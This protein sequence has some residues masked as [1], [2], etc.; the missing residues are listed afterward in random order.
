MTSKSLLGIN[1]LSPVLFYQNPIDIYQTQEGS[2]QVYGGGPCEINCSRMCNQNLASND[3]ASQ[4]QRQKLIQN[5][6]RVYSSLYTMNLAGLTSYQRPLKTPQIVEQNSTPYVVPANVYWNQM[7]DRARPSHQKTKVASG[8]TYHT[9]STRHSITRN[10]PGAM[11]PGGIGVDIKHNS[12]DRYLNKIKGKAPLRR[13]IIPPSYGEP[14]PFNRAFP[15]YG[16]KTFKTSIIN[17]CDCSD[18]NNNKQDKLIYGPISNAIQDKILSVKYEFHIGDFVLAKKYEN[19]NTLYKGEIISI[20]GD[21]YTVK[22]D[23]NI[24]RVISYCE[25]LIYFDC[26]CNIQLSLQEE[27][28]QNEKQITPT[29]LSPDIELFCKLLNLGTSEGV[30]Y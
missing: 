13:G 9:S 12:Y 3:P 4:Y 25:L 27:I 26:N 16:G 29:D 24:T 2:T 14:I 19:D 18:N 28:I 17:G 7:S 11:S 21:N 30:I 8:S 5:T 15:V 1:L 10:R 22:F 23:D 20:I 6:V